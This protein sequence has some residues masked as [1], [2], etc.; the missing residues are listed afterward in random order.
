MTMTEK[1]SWRKTILTHLAE[2]EEVAMDSLHEASEGDDDLALAEEAV[3]GLE[4]EGLAWDDHR[5]IKPRAG[6][7]AEIR[8]ALAA[9]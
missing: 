2:D 3:E 9:E 1:W 6:K 8:A 4:R 5:V 7:E